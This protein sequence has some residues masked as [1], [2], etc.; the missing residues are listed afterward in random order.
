MSL[1]TFSISCPCECGA[2][3][4][5]TDKGF[6]ATTVKVAACFGPAVIRKSDAYERTI[7]TTVI[8]HRDGLVAFGG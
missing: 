2:A 7:P 8:S 3:V 6:A 5:A 4:T 1:S